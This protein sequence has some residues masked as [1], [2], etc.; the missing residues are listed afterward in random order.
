MADDVRWFDALGK[1]RE[2]PKPATGKLMGSRNDSY[3]PYCQKC[4]DKRLMRAMAERQK[5]KAAQ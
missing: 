3:G 5:E 1:C 4:A 2:C